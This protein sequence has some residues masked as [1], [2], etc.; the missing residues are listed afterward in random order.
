MQRN[1]GSAETAFVK[2]PITAGASGPLNTFNSND[3]FKLI[4]D[5]DINV[6]RD[7]Y[8]PF[9]DAFGLWE[10]SVN[11]N[12][13]LG[14][15]TSLSLVIYMDWIDS[16]GVLQDRFIIPLGQRSKV[17]FRN[18]WFIR[19]FAIFQSAGTVFVAPNYAAVTYFSDFPSGV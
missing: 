18:D 13:A 10:V 9:T 7:V 8:L 2:T 15:T 16:A 17:V 5:K 3:T 14:V 12:T 6:C 19:G 1:Y 11:Y 4:F